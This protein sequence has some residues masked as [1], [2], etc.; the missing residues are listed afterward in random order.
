M[1]QLRPDSATKRSW[2]V[3]LATDS[4]HLG[5]C[6]Q[7][8]KVMVSEQVVDTCLVIGRQARGD[9]L[10][11]LLFDLLASA[12]AHRAQL[13]LRI[14]LHDGAIA[15]SRQF[16][17]IHPTLSARVLLNEVRSRPDSADH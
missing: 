16:A 3:R 8:V 15:D 1:P 12:L 11:V 9:G 4:H 6:K 5:L 2:R 13:T 14:F 7:R 17:P 10:V